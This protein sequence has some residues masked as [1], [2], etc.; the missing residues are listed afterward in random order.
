MIHAIEFHEV[1]ALCCNRFVQ[2]EG[3]KLEKARGNCVYT[4][5]NSIMDP[6]PSWIPDAAPRN[7][8][9]ANTVFAHHNNT[10]WALHEPSQLTIIRLLGLETD[11]ATNFDGNL[12]HPF[13]AY[14][15]VDQK[16]GEMM[17]FGYAFQP[18]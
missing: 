14:P 13:T 5:M 8:K 9:F 6:V 17:T 15:R 7:K 16:S 18:P 12:K 4:G 11:G 10:R 1:I 2:T 3:L